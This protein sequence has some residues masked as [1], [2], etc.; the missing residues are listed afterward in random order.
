MLISGPTVPAYS[1][2]ATTTPAATAT[3]TM[4]QAAFDGD[5]VSRAPTPRNS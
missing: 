5:L 2:A 1:T 3:G 4:S